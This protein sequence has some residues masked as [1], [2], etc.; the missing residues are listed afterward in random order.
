M[1][2]SA[3]HP[4]AS[5]KLQFE[6]AFVEEL[7]QLGIRIGIAPVEKA[8]REFFRTGVNFCSA[9][10]PVLRHIIQKHI[11]DHDAYRRLI[12]GSFSEGKRRAGD[13]WSGLPDGYSGLKRSE[14]DS[15]KQ[16]VE[17]VSGVL[18]D[19]SRTKD[20]SHV[21]RIIL[22]IGAALNWASPEGTANLTP[23]GQLLSDTQKAIESPP[24]PVAREAA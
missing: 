12:K 13:L 18:G 14:P 3:E 10:P 5:D 20:K 1:D 7:N 15:T 17:A 6:K 23:V 22:A 9:S 19:F 24:P 8:S 2:R 4:V 11:P 16:A 21:R